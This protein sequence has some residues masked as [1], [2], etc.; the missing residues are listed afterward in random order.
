MINNRIHVQFDVANKFIYFTYLILCYRNILSLYFITTI[1]L[2]LTKLQ[3]S[4]V[5]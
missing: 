2:T 3:N 1:R 5:V 4:Y